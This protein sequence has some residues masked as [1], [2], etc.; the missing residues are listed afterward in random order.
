[1]EKLEL[2][3]NFERPSNWVAFISTI[4]E[5]RTIKRIKITGQV[6]YEANFDMIVDIAHL[7]RKTCNIFFLD[8]CADFSTGKSNLTAMDICAMTPTHVRHLTV[9]ITDIDEAMTVLHQFRRLSSAK[10]F[11]DHCPSWDKFDAWLKEHRKGS[12][13]YRNDSSTCVWL[14]QNNFLYKEIEGSNKRIKLT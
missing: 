13:Y 1:V 4:I 10:F 5:L 7:L 11:F 6:I 12:T 8:I 3:F 14:R 2:E 9:S